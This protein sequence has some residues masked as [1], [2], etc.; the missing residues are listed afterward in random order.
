[1]AR[2]ALL[3]DLQHS[4][5][6]AKVRIC[7]QVKGVTYRRIAPS[8]G[9]LLWDVPVPR[10]ALDGRPII[11]ADLIV[12]QLDVLYPAPALVPSETDLRAYS[13]LLEGWADAALGGVVRR[14]TWGP[15]DVRARMARATAREVTRGPLARLV[16]AVL[17][18]R[19]APLACTA[20]EARDALKEH[21]RVLE[22][23][24]G[25]RP[26]LLGRSPTRAD[27][28]AFAQL[29][30]VRRVAEGLSFDSWPAVSAWLGRLD[31]MPA[32]GTALSA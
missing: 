5:V 10:L 12:R 29:A 6:C 24:L 22:A 9:D 26:F 8:V 3:Y 30:C 2:E 19:A 25:D 1:M 14:L 18:R 15:E 31:D 27:F 32:I 23:M 20:G 11:R 21:V 28:A 13:D 7:L 4:P 17:S 16:A